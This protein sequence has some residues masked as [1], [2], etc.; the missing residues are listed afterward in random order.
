MNLHVTTGDITTIPVD[1]IVNAANVTLL[2]GG[3]VDGAIHTAAGPALREACL[4][5]DGCDPGDAKTTAAF[6]LPAQWVIHTVG[7]LWWDGRERE[8]EVLASCYRRCLEEAD[9]VGARTVSFPAISTGAFRFPIYPACMT[10][11]ATL[12]TTN[13]QVQEAVL[14]CFDDAVYEQYITLLKAKTA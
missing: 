14:V 9:K 3:G 5:L 4:P 1:A 13:T 2:G 12:V 10:A 7:P 8:T 6:G 11:L